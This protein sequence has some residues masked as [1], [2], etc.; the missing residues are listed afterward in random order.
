MKNIRFYFKPE[1]LV[2][3]SSIKTNVSGKFGT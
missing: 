2:D 3:Y 1:K